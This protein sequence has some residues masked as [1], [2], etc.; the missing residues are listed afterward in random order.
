V[1]AVRIKRNDSGGILGQCL[2]KSPPEA[3]GLS[4]ILLVSQ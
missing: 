2:L 4:S 1:L 3:V